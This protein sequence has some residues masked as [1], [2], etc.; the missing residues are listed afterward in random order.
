MGSPGKRAVKRVC[1]CV[2]YD[3]MLLL[4]YDAYVCVRLIQTPLIYGTSV[5]SICGEAA[6]PA[7]VVSSDRSSKRL[8]R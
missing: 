8:W 4:L 5:D 2:F 1:V 6:S 3:P 7:A